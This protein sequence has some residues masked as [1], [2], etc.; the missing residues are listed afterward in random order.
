M[1]LFNLVTGTDP[2]APYVLAMLGLPSKEFMKI[3]PRFR[4]AYLVSDGPYLAL[5]TRTGGGNRD[6]YET[7]NQRL[8]EIPG[9]VKDFDDDFDSTYAHWWYK[10]PEEHTAHATDLIQKVKEA[11]RRLTTPMERFKEAI[12]TLEK[13]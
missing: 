5:M 10:V 13:P 12:K 8:R 4:D 6:D 1:S 9:F 3:V 7:E 11:G 2:L